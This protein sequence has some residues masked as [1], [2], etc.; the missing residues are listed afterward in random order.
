MKKIIFFLV[1]CI[2]GLATATAQINSY[3]FAYTAG[4]YSEI[5]GGTTV[6][7]GAAQGADSLRLENYAFVPGDTLISEIATVTGYP[8]GFNFNLGSQIFTHFAISP[9]GFIYLGGESFTVDATEVSSDINVSWGSGTKNP[10]LSDNNRFEEG[11]TNLLGFS[12][13]TA[14]VTSDGSNDISATTADANTE[15]S[16]SLS[17]TAGSRVLT[18][19]F[20]KII[21]SWSATAMD[22]VD[23]QIRL[24]E[25]DSKVE[26]IFNDFAQTDE[27]VW[28]EIGLKGSVLGNTKYVFIDSDS[29][30]STA[31]ADVTGNVNLRN[32]VCD[33]GA[34]FTFTPPP[35]CVAPASKPTGLEMEATSNSIGGSFAPADADK[36]LVLAG[37]TENIALIGTNDKPKADKSYNV[38]DSINGKWRVIAF[39]SAT[40]FSF[41]GL[42][43]STEYT[44]AVY[45][46][47]TECLGGPKYYTMGTPLNDVIKTLPG[48]P[49]LSI[50]EG[51]FTG[52]KLAAQANAANNP[53]IVAVNSGQWDVDNNQ[54]QL[55]DGVFGTPTLNM[56]TGD[57]LTGGGKIIY[58]GPASNAIE[59]TG[60]APNKLVNFAAWSYDETDN[61]ISSTLV[62]LN[63][64][65]WGALPYLLDFSQYAAY[66]IPVD[67]EQEGN[68]FELKQNNATR[69]GNLLEA[70][71]TGASP[72]ASA[73][74]SIATQYLQLAPG[75]SRLVLSGILTHTTGSRPYVTTG[76]TEWEENDNMAFLV[77]KIGE[78]DYIPVYTINASNAA[79]F[80]TDATAAGSYS[81][82]VIPIEG[83]GNE[84]VKV[85]IAWT[86]HKTGTLLW[87]IAKFLI[88]EKSDHEAPINLT[89]DLASIVGNQA[90][91]TWERHANGTESVWE[92]RYRPIDTEWNTP[93][94]TTD[95]NYLFTTLP[96]NTKVEVSVRAV[97]GP[98]TYSPWTTP[99]SFKTAYGLPYNENFNNYDATSFGTNSGWTLS[100]SSP[101]YL[102]WDEIAR[103]LRFGLRQS[104]PP[105]YATALLPK[106][107]FGDGSANYRLA[108]DLSIENP[109]YPINSTD[110][111]YVID[112]T[113][114]GE[115]ILK[116]YHDVSGKET[117]D[118]EGFSGIKQLGFKLV[119]GTR[120]N[121]AYLLDDV[122]IFPTCSVAVSNA[123][124]SEITTEGAKVSWEGEASEW[125][126]FIRKAGETTKDF[127]V[128]TEKDSL[129]TG[130]DE[131]TAYEVGITTSCVPGDT[132][133]V[134]IVRFTTRTSIPCGQA[135]H[136]EATSTTE[137]VSLT[138]ESEA[139]KFNVKL[140]A[141]GTD[142]WQ[143]RTVAG[144]TFTFTGLTHNTDYEYSIQ[145]IC[146]AEG[147]VSEYT[148]PATVKTVEITCLAPTNL[149]A[150]LLAYNSATLSWEGA[151]SK[152]ELSWAQTGNDWTVAVVEGKSYN[153]IDLIPQ[154]AYQAKVRAICAATDTSAYTDVYSFTTPAIPACPI[155]TGLSAG[156]I[157]D[158]SAILSWTADAANTSW[159]LRYRSG[160]SSSSIDVE[161]LAVSW[162]E[163]TG[164]TANTVYLW[165]VKAHCASTNNESVYA[166]QENFTTA[167]TSIT[168]VNSGALKVAVSNRLIS[169]LNPEGAYINNIRLYAVDGSLLQDF[170]VRST[171]NVL[172]QTYITQQIAIVNVIGKDTQAV[173]KV[174]VK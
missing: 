159:D 125:L 135:S 70:R 43:S 128:R 123:Q 50:S 40:T 69:R 157:N 61:A 49:Q 39:S 147:D 118:L 42:E 152:Y 4:T 10:V 167:S 145:T 91:I 168:S 112:N 77:K 100:P 26:L 88:E 62:K 143:E 35:A 22:A 11:A 6:Y 87:D 138:W 117:I 127:V 80:F 14:S 165:Q 73:Y 78:T 13:I 45:P 27:R 85:K 71:V 115:I 75:N 51:G 89:V 151:A 133:Q 122:S 2:V 9:N 137:S 53:V 16:Y 170:D 56:N 140:R 169:V 93:V 150:D 126:V 1:G 58:K 20:K 47:N 141:V 144:K 41:D 86:T 108:F 72:Q 113:A 37:L 99:I 68:Y 38:G 28:A 74:S 164:L 105:K 92:V 95:V 31:T 60:L 131:A 5:S 8:I 25:A 19:Q 15:I 101:L 161:G 63:V 142:A 24:Y 98:N 82:I 29:N 136:I 66:G 129:F 166:S 121:G 48:A 90:K 83:F 57:Q 139:Y 158:H 104:N 116:K 124:A 54:N 153:L 130:L 55:N 163:L 46:A 23:V 36:Y 149:V 155:P 134:T 132:A 119:E 154:T 76:Y 162:Y 94:Q 171:D 107:D 64:T 96:A 32:T 111:I 52:L 81:N 84:T 110:S 12:R 103:A 33:N 34:T 114:E 17:G 59:V 7:S 102:A 21:L 65:T 67:W 160:T 109:D 146:D 44:V 120:D 18:I 3:N 173:F 156:S 97:I 172:I 148:T 106:L 174:A 30:W 79:N